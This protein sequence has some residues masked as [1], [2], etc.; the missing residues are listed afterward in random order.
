V[1]VLILL[2]RGLD[3]PQIAHELGVPVR[4]TRHHLRDAMQTLGAT[5]PTNAV[6]LAIAAQILPADVANPK[7]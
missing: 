3:L 1:Q 5:N 4:D 6:A 7:E 2:S